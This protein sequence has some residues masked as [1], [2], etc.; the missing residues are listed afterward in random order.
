MKEKELKPCPFC[1]S[2]NIKFDKCTKRV[3]CKDCYATGGLITLY[4]NKG[5]SEDEAVLAA[6]N[7]RCADA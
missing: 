3:R 1:G 7:E 5:L 4:I 2:R 6:W